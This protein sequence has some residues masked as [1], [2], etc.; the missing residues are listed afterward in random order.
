MRLLGLEIKRVLM[1]PMTRIVLGAALFFSFLLAYIP[2]TFVYC[3][4]PQVVTGDKEYLTGLEAIRAEKQITQG[5]SG[6][7]TQE[8]IVYAVACYQD[9]LKRYGVD[10]TYELSDTAKSELDPVKYLFHGIREAYATEGGIA[11]NIM[12]L[13]AGN[14]GDFYAA[15]RKHLTDIMRLEQKEHPAAGRNAE[16]LYGKVD[17]PFWYA[18]GVSA[19]AIEYEGLL[20]LVLFLCCTVVCA[21]VFSSEYQTGADDILRCTK[22]GRRKLAVVKIVSA[23]MICLVVTVIGMGIWILAT[24]VFWGQEG[25]Q[26]S[27]QMLFSVISLVDLNVGGLIWTEALCSVIMLLSGVCLT[28]FLSSRFSNNMLAMVTALLV[29][30]LPVVLGWLIPDHIVNLVKCVFPAGGIGLQ[31]GFLYD[32]LEMHYLNIGELAIWTPFLI[33]AFAVVEIPLW[34]GLTIWTYQRHVLK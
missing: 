21:P 4:N 25:M 3:R 17:M 32:L 28:L 23:L 33:M 14:L 19:D 34:I 7:I 31:N 6:E 11:A 30:F 16:A 29:C 10:Y 2:V 22:S 12:D 13:E 1:S 26:T 8:K 24:T 9:C 18:Y 15:C 20:V 27:V 5:I